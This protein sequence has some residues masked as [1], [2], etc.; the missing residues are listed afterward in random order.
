MKQSEDVNQCIEDIAASGYASIML[1]CIQGK[2]Q[3]GISGDICSY[4]LKE[5][6]PFK[7]VGDMVL[8]MDE[9]CNWLSAPQ[10]TTDPR[11]MN[12]GMRRSYEEAAAAHPEVIKDKIL[13]RSRLVPFPQALEAKEVLVA[14]VKYRQNSSMQGSI[15]GKLTNGV[16]VGFRSA[17]E[18]MRMVRMIE[19][20]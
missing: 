9:I 20:M 16:D 17:L 8:K 15:R 19:I 7:S 11:F 5:P 13:D 4:Y 1:I 14:I 6:V 2:T 18:L 10:R 12:K 3:D